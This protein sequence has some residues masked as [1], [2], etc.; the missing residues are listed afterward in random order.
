MNPRAS[1]VPPVGHKAAIAAF[2]FAP[3][4]APTC[5]LASITVV[6]LPK[7]EELVPPLGVEHAGTPPVEIWF[8]N[9][10]VVQLKDSTPPKVVEVGAGRSAPAKARKVGAAAL[11]DTGPA[12]MKSAF[13]FANAAVNVPEP[14]T[15][16]PETENIEGIDSP[17]LVTVPFPVLHE[18]QMGSVPFE[19]KHCPLPPI[20]KRAF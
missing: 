3:K 5:K 8:K 16:V 15:G 13:W 19:V 7:P 4:S 14:V 10:P 17:T 1:T 20:P 6:P 12:M 11:P 9:W 18:P 2:T